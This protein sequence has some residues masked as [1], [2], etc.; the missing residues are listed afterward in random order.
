MR[1]RRASIKTSLR[2]WSVR[3][4][5]LRRLTLAAVWLILTTL[6]PVYPISDSYAGTLMTDDFDLGVW[7]PFMKR[8][9]KSVPVCIWS[10]WDQNSPFTLT[11]SS[12][13]GPRLQITNSIN[14]AIPYRV[15]WL[16]G[17]G[18]NRRERLSSGVPSSRSYVSADTAACANGP[19]G[20]L[21]LTINAR[22]LRD[23]PPGIYADTLQLM[24]TPL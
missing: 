17:R 14:D 15:H 13:S 21:R 4:R 8:V 24:I 9:Q 10:E 1:L 5:E 20:M 7:S 2:L 18:F 12:A 16:S 22:H 11:V 6:S 23:A 19:T 3:N